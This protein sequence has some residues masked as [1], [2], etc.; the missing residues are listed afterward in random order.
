MPRNENP[1]WVQKHVQLS[2]VII[3]LYTLFNVVNVII[4]NHYPP[5]HPPNGYLYKVP[6]PV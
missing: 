6:T 2:C 3:Y 1:E 4:A 5:P